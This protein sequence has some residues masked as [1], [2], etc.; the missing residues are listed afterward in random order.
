MG[1]IEKDLKEESTS[2]EVSTEQKSSKSKKGKG[3][4]IILLVLLTLVLLLVGAIYLGYRKITKA[5]EPVDLEVEY[6]EQDYK[7]IMKELG[8]D[9]DGSLLCVDCTTPSFSDPNEVE[10]TITNAQAS[11]AFEYINQH[12]SVAQ[13]SGTQIKMGEGEA[14]LSTTLTF[15]ERT[16]PIYMVGTLSKRTENSLNGEISVLKV[17][18]F[19][20]PAPTIPYIKDALLSVANKKLSSAGDTLRIDSINITPKGVDFKGLLPTKAE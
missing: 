19:N 9:I 16:L 3:C 20:I 5:M 4:I 10:A 2:S 15:R 8:V 11:A 6:T 13:V 1:E 12:M 18:A 17:G 7:D 14:E